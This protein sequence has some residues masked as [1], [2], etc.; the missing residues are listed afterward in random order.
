MDFSSDH[1]WDNWER[2][3]WAGL[4]HFS[5]QQIAHLVFFGFFFA[6]LMLRISK[7]KVMSVA[8]VMASYFI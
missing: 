4:T 8:A 7:P 5:A 2:T 6:F 3:V 1:L